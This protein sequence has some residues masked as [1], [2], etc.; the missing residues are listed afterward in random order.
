MGPPEIPEPAETTEA[1]NDAEVP[2][3]TAHPR[4]MAAAARVLGD[5][6]KESAAGGEGA[7]RGNRLSTA[8]WTDL[9]D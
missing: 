5:A 1:I 6:V 2:K 4:D 3:D 7:D 9:L 8:F